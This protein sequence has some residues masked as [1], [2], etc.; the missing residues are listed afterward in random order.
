MMKNVLLKSGPMEHLL[1]L[2]CSSDGSGTEK[3]EFG[4]VREFPK[5]EKSGSGI[6][7]MKKVVFGRELETRVSGIFRALL[8]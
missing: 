2:R 5:F 1:K 7:C 8:Y 6:S 4:Q 3:V